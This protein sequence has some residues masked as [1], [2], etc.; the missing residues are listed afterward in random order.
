M[1][2]V[3]VV[4]HTPKDISAATEYGPLVYVFGGET[5]RSSMYVPEFQKELIKR[6][7]DLDFNQ[8]RDY[9][10]LAGST[11]IIAVT[12]AA[13]GAAWGSFNVLAFEVQNKS[14]K[15]I[16]IGDMADVG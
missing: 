16:P 14:Y 8:K 13:V 4:E 15:P 1:S 5:S 9:I 12:V 11:V 7:E 6:L 10:L 2:K 3:F